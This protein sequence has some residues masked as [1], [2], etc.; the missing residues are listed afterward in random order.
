VAPDLDESKAALVDASRVRLVT[1]GSDEFFDLVEARRGRARLEYTVKKGDDLKRIGKR[2]GLTVADLER[3]NRFGAH[4]T[5]L[6]IGQKLVV[7][8]QMTRTEK[9]KVAC[10]LVPGGAIGGA[11]GAPAANAD[12]ASEAG[13]VESAPARTMASAPPAAQPTD[14]D[15]PEALLPRPPPP[16][17]RP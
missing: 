2:F 7:Y 12:G 4:H 11:V 10:K 15:D 6:R 9:E 3:I 1:T 8:R 13:A 16:D 5:D 14:P 17:G